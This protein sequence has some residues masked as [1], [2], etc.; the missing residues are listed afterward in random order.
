MFKHNHQC[1]FLS[2]KNRHSLGFLLV[3]SPEL[4]W[5]SSHQFC[6]LLCKTHCLFIYELSVI[7]Y[8]GH[9]RVDLFPASLVLTPE[10]QSLF[11]RQFSL[12]PGALNSS[13][14]PW[15]LLSRQDGWSVVFYSAAIRDE[16][17]RSVLA[18]RNLFTSITACG[19]FFRMVWVCPAPQ[20][21]HNMKWQFKKEFNYL[22]NFVNVIS[23]SWWL[24]RELRLWEGSRAVHV[25]CSKCYFLRYSTCVKTAPFYPIPVCVYSKNFLL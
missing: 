19:V 9:V 22:D 17:E 3:T 7:V 24:E 10:T 20:H 6:D 13:F 25:L 2:A 4:S 11:W 23:K 8:S 14:L 21:N 1:R 18:N 12:I 15:N 16:P 5:D